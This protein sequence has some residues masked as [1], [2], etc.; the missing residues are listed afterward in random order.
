MFPGVKNGSRHGFRRKAALLL[1]A[2]TFAASLAIPA[3]AVPTYQDTQREQQQWQE[4]IGENNERVG[5]LNEERTALQQEYDELQAKV[6]ELQTVVDEYDRQIE[7]LELQIEIANQELD[8]KYTVYC[9]RVREIEEKGKTS[10]W[11]IIFQATSL[12]DLLGRIDY[13]EE[14]MRYDENALT[15]IESQIS[16]LDIKA[17]RLNSIRADRNYTERQLRMAQ[18]KLVDKIDQRIEEINSLVG[19]NLEYQEELNRLRQESL[20]ILNREQ[21]KDYSGTQD[22][23]T[24]YQKHV[25]E[26][27][28]L[29]KTP[30]GA[31]IVAFTLQFNGGEYVWGGASPSEGFDCS[32]M[33]YYVYKQFGY[34]INR[35]ARPQYAYDGREVSFYE[36]QAGDMVFF[37]APG[38][39]T[40]AHVG[41][42]IGDGL[43]IHAA[44]RKSGIKVSD[45]YSNYYTANWKGARRVIPDGM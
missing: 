29:R 36:L 22:A 35:T 2:I 4:R 18:N 20:A 9:S 38:E 7:E 16:V 45:L 42:Y 17:E 28:E 41:M 25:V 10:Y 11:S 8:D 21:G 33:M 24:I 34:T 12:K 13:V 32:G 5:V 44:S 14:I 40:V 15:E 27:G 43:F 30:L 26:S 23:A 19:Q 39:T 1:S 3:Q 6:D 31:Q 37:H